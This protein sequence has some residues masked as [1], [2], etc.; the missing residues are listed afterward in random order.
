[1]AP[2]CGRDGQVDVQGDEEAATT[3]GVSVRELAYSP[4]F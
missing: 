1:M 3:A 2:A 4:K